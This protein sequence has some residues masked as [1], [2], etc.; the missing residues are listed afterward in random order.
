MSVWACPE[1]RDTVSIDGNG[2]PITTSI[3]DIYD[4]DYSNT[5]NW[6]DVDLSKAL[7]A[8]PKIWDQVK[9]KD[10]FWDEFN[11]KGYD[12]TMV[13][14]V[15]VDSV[16]RLDAEHLAMHEG[17]DDALNDDA[18]TDQIINTI[19]SSDDPGAIVKNIDP[20]T[21]NK[22]ETSQ[23][24]KL[25]S[26]LT[27]EQQKGL[28]AKHLT[29]DVLSSIQSVG[30]N[31]DNIDRGELAKALEENSEFWGGG[32]PAPEFVL[33]NLLP[34][35]QLYKVGDEFWINNGGKN[36][37]SLSTSKGY[38]SI[39]IKEGGWSHV[40]SSGDNRPT[41]LVTQNDK[42]EIVYYNVPEG[43][44]GQIDV[45]ENTVNLR[46]AMRCY[47][48]DCTENIFS[49]DAK[50]TYSGETFSISNI[51]G[52]APGEGIILSGYSFEVKPEGLALATI[53]SNKDYIVDIGSTGADLWV[54]DGH[55]EVAGD[56]TLECNNGKTVSDLGDLY[57]NIV[58]WDKATLKYSSGTE[59]KSITTKKASVLKESEFQSKLQYTKTG[60][61]Y[62]LSLTDIGYLKSDKMDGGFEIEPDKSIQIHKDSNSFSIT[63]TDDTYAVDTE[64]GITFK[65]TKADGKTVEFTPLGST[66]YTLSQKQAEEN[67]VWSM[68]CD[69]GDVMTTITQET[70][71][72]N[73][74]NLKTMKIFE[75]FELRL[76]DNDQ[77]MNSIGAVYTKHQ[78]MEYTA[79]DYDDLKGSPSLHDT[80]MI[81]LHVGSL[82][83]KEHVYG[84]GEVDKLF[85]ASEKSIY[86]EAVRTEKRYENDDPGV[87]LESDPLDKSV[88]GIF[89][90]NI[91]LEQHYVV[92]EDDNNK[93]AKSQLKVSGLGSKQGVLNLGP[94]RLL[95]AKPYLTQSNSI[96]VSTHGDS[97][98]LTIDEN[99]DERL[100]SVIKPGDEKNTDIHYVGIAGDEEGSIL[101]NGKMSPLAL[102]NVVLKFEDS[103][104][105]FN[106][107]KEVDDVKNEVPVIVQE[108]D[109]K[110]GLDKLLVECTENCDDAP[111]KEKTPEQ[112]IDD[113]E[114][115][116]D[117]CNE[118]D[119]GCLKDLNKAIQENGGTSPEVE[120]KIAEALGNNAEIEELSKKATFNSV[121]FADNKKDPIL[122]I[123]TLK[124]STAD[125]KVTVPIVDA[126]DGS[127]VRIVY[128]DGQGK[129]QRAIQKVEDGAAAFDGIDISKVQN[130]IVG[131]WKNSE[132]GSF[133]IQGSR[134]SSTTGLNYV[135]DDNEKIQSTKKFHTDAIDKNK[136]LNEKKDEAKKESPKTPEEK[137]EEAE[138]D[139]DAAKGVVATAEKNNDEAQKELAKDPSNEK[140]QEKADATSKALS[141]SEDNKAQKEAEANKAK[142]EAT[143]TKTLADK[144]EVAETT[145]KESVSAAAAEQDAEDKKLKAEQ[146]L[147]IKPSDPEAQKKVVETDAAL[148]AAQE[149]K[150]KKDAAALQAV[151]ELAAAEALAEST[152]DTELPILTSYYDPAKVPCW[153]GGPCEDLTDEEKLR[154]AVK[155]Q[156]GYFLGTFDF[157]TD[158]ELIKYLKEHEQFETLTKLRD[159]EFELKQF[160]AQKTMYE[161]KTKSFQEELNNIDKQIE[162]NKD[163]Q[164]ILSKYQTER[165]VKANELAAYQDSFKAGAGLI[166]E[167]TGDNAIIQLQ[168][169]AEKKLSQLAD[170]LSQDLE[171]IKKLHGQ[172]GEDKG[173][174]SDGIS[175]TI[176]IV[177]INNDFTNRK[178]TYSDDPIELDT[179]NAFFS[180][181]AIIKDSELDKSISTIREDIGLEDKQYDDSFRVVN[182]AGQDYAVFF[183]DKDM[184][185]FAIEL[186]ETEKGF[187]TQ[188]NWREAKRPDKGFFDRETLFKVD[189][190]NS[191]NFF[192]KLL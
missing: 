151:Q 44:S 144:K 45:G 125:K 177:K 187:E 141:A 170:P 148:V 71:F 46:N 22:L 117:K 93:V 112:Q 164:N 105:L 146:E 189:V 99:G 138:A 114:K 70:I 153:R 30:G 63:K 188:G 104:S 80:R 165:L 40:G 168:R 27:P 87:M 10:E 107:P 103:K 15:P 18:Q 28:D 42:G 130:V 145:K 186:K 101:F 4:C 12:S 136:K 59:F 54:K 152:G 98:K 24:E 173:T 111:E 26:Y 142:E 20:K 65:L 25:A 50:V 147:A 132:A 8:Q 124:Y 143:A 86:E 85:D 131:K 2:N 192:L 78:G 51:A 38:K 149:E 89:N 37:F 116:A 77:T 123:S 162:N 6:A 137:V 56:A 53:Q 9:N 33:S 185:S 113:A 16:Y 178:T 140:K 135:E 48:Q 19:T 118:G 3:C 84:M 161:A 64:K 190:D 174:S 41:N 169:D 72:G 110:L 106:T 171:Y 29:P 58:V 92:L 134:A 5:N 81:G 166:G 21:I 47:N 82:S 109:E 175:E 172:N 179:V 184:Q 83:T 55:L 129:E 49:Q 52:D 133:L 75:T 7:S 115:N 88:M 36:G 74:K 43:K 160:E 94:N 102:T 76:L 67:H 127:Y 119:V 79:L 69:D 96:T 108:T 11:R 182:Q 73:T 32:E 183:S 176:K 90:G 14:N 157:K 57:S 60:S 126:P 100:T 155:R 66:D 1:C 39:A 31:L 191:K 35:S 156:T 158:E 68:D 61:N 17:L 95:V 181:V 121:E 97:L 154:D 91:D 23:V 13:N 120:T 159:A 167:M 128:T 180:K 139:A 163:N 34:G 62:E 150:A 122:T